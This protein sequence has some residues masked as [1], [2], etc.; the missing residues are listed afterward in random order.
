MSLPFRKSVP[1]E[2]SASHVLEEYTENRCFACFT[3]AWFSRLTCRLSLVRGVF[4]VNKSRIDLPC[5][6]DEKNASV[7][8]DMH[9]S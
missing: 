7:V 3:F 5:K 1:R 6:K 8:P 4:E 9:I 2:Q